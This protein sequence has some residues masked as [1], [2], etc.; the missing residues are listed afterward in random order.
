MHSRAPI[1]PIRRGADPEPPPTD[2]LATVNFLNDTAMRLG[3]ATIYGGGPCTVNATSTCAVVV[4]TPG[5]APWVVIS[6]DSP[7]DATARNLVLGIADG[8]WAAHNGDNPA[9]TAAEMWRQRTEREAQPPI[10]G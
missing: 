3:T 10:P 2:L 4:S 7:D 6:G 9:E 5:C 1:I 8:V